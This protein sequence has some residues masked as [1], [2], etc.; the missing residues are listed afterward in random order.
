MKAGSEGWM[1]YSFN[2]K[3]PLAD[4]GRRRWPCTSRHLRVHR[5][6]VLSC[7]AIKVRL[8]RR[9]WSTIRARIV[10]R[11]ESL[12]NIRTQMR[13]KL[14]VIIQGWEKNKIREITLLGCSSSFWWST[15]MRSSTR[16]PLLVCLWFQQSRGPAVGC[17]PSGGTDP[18]PSLGSLN[19]VFFISLIIWIII[20]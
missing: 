6:F 5:N 9:K 12:L 14:F 10:G 11:F 16:Y 2:S 3:H 20:I 7:I 17:R 18:S 4:L 13:I 1:A 19:N 8:G 15:S